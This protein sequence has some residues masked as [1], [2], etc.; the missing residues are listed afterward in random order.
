MLSEE[1]GRSLGKLYLRLP[2]ALLFAVCNKQNAAHHVAL[3]EY[4]HGYE[5]KIF[6]VSVGY[7]DASFILRVGIGLPVL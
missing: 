4:R 6:I 1:G 5:R 2:S 3:C 7:E